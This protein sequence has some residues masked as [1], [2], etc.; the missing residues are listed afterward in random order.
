MMSRWI[1]KRIFSLVW[2]TLD[3]VAIAEG[4]LSAG[5]EGRVRKRQELGDLTRVISSRRV[6]DFKSSSGTGV[7]ARQPEITL[8][9]LLLL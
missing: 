3:E 2:V 5:G 4:K 9:A 1:A 7:E 8:Q 6:S